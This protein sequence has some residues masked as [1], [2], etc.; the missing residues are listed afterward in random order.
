MRISDLDF[1]LIRSFAFIFGVFKEKVKRKKERKRKQKKKNENIS[2]PMF[3]KGF[4]LNIRLR[5]GKTTT[6]FA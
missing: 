2:G 3:I 5:L 1:F 6:R 4:S